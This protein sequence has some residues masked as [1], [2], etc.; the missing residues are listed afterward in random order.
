MKFSVGFWDSIFGDKI[1]LELPN[2]DGKII[3]RK[4]S[5]RWLE[6]MKSEGQ[7]KD[8]DAIRVHM[9]DPDKGYTIG[10]WIIGKDIDEDT[11][12]KFRDKNTGDLYAITYYENGEPK[13]SVMI[14][15]LWDETKEKMDS[16]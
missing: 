6:K 12:N 9:I 2:S 15:S 16:I 7:I 10:H 8:I 13:V 11:V 14:K 1:L 5:K 3:K 4:V